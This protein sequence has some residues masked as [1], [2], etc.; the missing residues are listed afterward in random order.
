MSAIR[1]VIFDL[2]GT[3]VRTGRPVFRRAMR[4]LLDVDRRAWTEYVRTVL[5]VTPFDSRE[6][7]LDRILADLGTATSRAQRESAAARLDEELTSVHTLPGVPA[8]LDFLRRRGLRLGL[9]SNLASPYGEVLDAPGL[10]G[11]FDAVALSCERGLAKPEPALYTELCAELNVEPGETL[12]VGDSPRNDVAA[13]RRLGMRSLQVGGEATT[14]DRLSVFA[15]GWRDLDNQLAPLVTVGRPLQLG[16]ERVTLERF[17]PVPDTSQ[18]RYNLVMMADAEDEAGASQRIYVK[19]Y[20]LPESAHVEAFSRVLLREVG[21]ETPPGGILGDS[22]PVHW[23]HDAA[24]DRIREADI[25]PQ[26]AFEFGR[27]GAATFLFANADCRPRNAFLVGDGSHRRMVTFD[28]EHCLFNLALDLTGVHDPGDPREIDA[29]G[30]VELERRVSKRVISP[31]SCRRNYRE[32]LGT[33]RGEPELVAAFRNGWIDLSHR[34]Q[35]CRE[36]LEGLLRR[37]VYTE[38]Y[39]IIGTRA[40]RRAMAEIDVEDLLARVAL[41]P[42]EVLDD[43]MGSGS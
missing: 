4:E 36:R 17:A 7:F 29:L 39:L 41:D 22:E 18:G 25:T 16:A 15:L 6:A 14:R 19:R 8:L 12:M 35:Q 1:A 38:P 9:L 23:S 26:I 2:Y 27:H 10:S 42:V 3:L 5:L 40:Y 21:L 13:P 32:F 31:R 24:G 20:L 34:A 33:R 37:R 28:H 43:W 30:R 11:R